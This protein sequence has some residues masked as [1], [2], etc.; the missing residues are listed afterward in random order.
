MPR[1]RPNSNP[2]AGSAR[3]QS[4]SGGDR[5]AGRIRR[6]YFRIGDQPENVDMSRVGDNI[7]FL[8]PERSIKDCRARCN[9]LKLAAYERKCAEA[10]EAAAQTGEEPVMPPP[11]RK[12]RSNASP[13]MQAIVTFGA[14]LND[15]VNAILDDPAQRDAFL[16]DLTR[17][18]GEHFDTEITAGIVHRDEEQPHIHFEMLTIANNGEAVTS[19][20]NRE[21]LVVLQDK[22]HDVLQ[23][24]IPEAERGASK[25]DMYDPDYR[26]PQELREETQAE[27]ERW[28][29][30]VDDQK[31]EFAQVSAEV[32]KKRDQLA[33]AEAKLAKAQADETSTSDNVTK[34][35]KRVET[36]EARLVKAEA[37]L[38][39]K[40]EAFASLLKFVSEDRLRVFEHTDPKYKN[41]FDPMDDEARAEV[42]E[43]LETLG[44]ALTDAQ[45]DALMTLTQTNIRNKQELDRAKEREAKAKKAEAEAERKS[46]AADEREVQLD[47]REG[48]LNKRE[49]A[50]RIREAALSAKEAALAVREK[51][52]A[53]AEKMVDVM[54]RGFKAIASGLL[55]ADNNVND[56]TKGPKGTMKEALAEANPMRAEI[57]QASA[58][59]DVQPYWDI[60][61]EADDVINGAGGAAPDPKKDPEPEPEPASGGPSMG[62]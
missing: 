11:Y 1:R 61:S 31:S 20:C 34:L 5:G 53:A 45:S 8:P 2:K 7:L 14:D 56:F 46:A 38:E 39:V 51:A 6:H 16:G 35:Q 55:G 26:S 15:S 60:L 40:N 54:K 13:T 59:I 33:S 32:N 42:R 44:L 62:M 4:I 9:E 3:I 25:I 23:H 24:Y 17:M 50:L 27:A 41:W 19:N 18:L 37:E 21:W 28:L 49:G 29:V 30:M 43:C 58:D 10:I 48:Q 36:Y 57:A 22:L 47:Q 52:V 12:L